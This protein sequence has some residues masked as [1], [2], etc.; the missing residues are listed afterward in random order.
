MRRGVSGVGRLAAALF[1]TAGLLATTA[2]AD[3]ISADEPFGN[4][5]QTYTKTIDRFGIGS[6]RTRFGALEFVGGLEVTSDSSAFGGMSSIRL[7][8]DRLSFIGIEDT[9]HWYSGTFIRHDGRLAGIS[10]FRIAPIRGRNGEPLGTKWE[11]DAESIAV[12][13]D[14]VLVGFE[15]D[16]R[17]DLYPLNDPQASGPIQTIPLPFPKR[18]LRT[19]RSLETVAVSPKDSPLHGATVTVAEMSINKAGDLYAG[20][21]DGPMRGAFFV[22]RDPPY[23]VS[24]GAFLPNGDLLLLERSLTLSLGF[25]IRIVRID[26]NAIRPG[27]TVQGKVIFQAGL[28]DQIDNLE[29]LSVN[30]GEDG[31]IY[32]LLVSD[33]NNSLLQRNLFLEFRLAQ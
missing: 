31:G 11:S 1:L 18:E 28:G 26:G 15:R 21:L 4:P 12:R 33:D 30:R 23:G 22:H 27:A 2:H 17:I 24:D 19:N 8:A 3:A 6:N 13:G 14:G 29:G 16:H 25:G 7:G 10:D 32:L 9:G 5:V 20:I